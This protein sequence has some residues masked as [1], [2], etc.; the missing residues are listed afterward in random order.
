LNS[1]LLHDVSHELRSPLA[2]IQVLADTIA[3]HPQDGLRCLTGIAQE[4][5]LLD[6]LVGDLLQAARLDSLAAGSKRESF[7]MQHWAREICSRLELTVQA[8]G[9]R[10]V[11]ELPDQDAEVQG[12][13]LPLVRALGNLVDN[14]VHALVN[15]QDPLIELKLHVD[16]AAW[17][18][19][20]RDN[21]SGIPE[22]HLEHVFRRF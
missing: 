13:S 5:N 18:L 19:T 17:F 7:S 4:V 9:I 3:T 16:E 14:S 2:R 6:Q 20:V 21:G 10:W 15:T 12:Y 8:E 1:R 11:C 22:A